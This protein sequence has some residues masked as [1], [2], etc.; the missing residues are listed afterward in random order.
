MVI[1][2]ST[3]EGNT[4]RRCCV[5]NERASWRKDR[6]PRPT[7]K[8]HNGHT[9]MTQLRTTQHMMKMG[10]GQIK[11]MRKVDEWPM[12]ISRSITRVAF[13]T[14]T[15]QGLAVTF[16][17]QAT[18]RIHGTSKA[19]GHLTPC[20]FKERCP[21]NGRTCHALNPT[22]GKDTQCVQ[23]N[24]VPSSCSTGK[25]TIRSV[26]R[27]QKRMPLSPSAKIHTITPATRSEASR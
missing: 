14:M 26:N 15:Q 10:W 21:L 9:R 22:S 13:M 8:Y 20:F 4:T 18:R 2:K 27:D 1:H 25:P 17:L 5:Q 16:I 6:R 3:R 19:D 7:L 12:H 23:A 11:D 24:S